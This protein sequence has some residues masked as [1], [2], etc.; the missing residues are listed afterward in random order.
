[1]STLPHHIFIKSSGKNAKIQ[2][3]IFFEKIFEIPIDKH[4]LK[5]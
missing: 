1:M 4:A 3:K 2:Q 5:C